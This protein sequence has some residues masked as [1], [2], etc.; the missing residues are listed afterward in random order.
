MPGFDLFIHRDGMK[1][2]TMVETYVMESDVFVAM[3]TDDYLDYAN[4]RRELVS[5]APHTTAG[6]RRAAH[7]PACD[8]RPPRNKQN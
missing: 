3:V 5:D 1:D 8:Q 7:P 6:R 2:G 4:C